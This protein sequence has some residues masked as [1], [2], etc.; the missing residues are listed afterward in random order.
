MRQRS[1]KCVAE[2]SKYVHRKGL[3]LSFYLSW[4]LDPV[5]HGKLQNKKKNEDTFGYDITLLNFGSC[6][7]LKYPIVM[8]LA[9]TCVTP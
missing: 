8:S 5:V 4:V 6:A 9:L 2:G 1:E 7:Q 3:Y